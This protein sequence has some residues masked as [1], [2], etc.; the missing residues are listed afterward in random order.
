MSYVRLKGRLR[1]EG[2]ELMHHTS[3][4]KP[5]RLNIEQPDETRRIHN[6]SSRHPKLRPQTRKDEVNQV[7]WLTGHA[8][9]L[10]ALRGRRVHSLT[11]RH[12]N[13]VRQ[14]FLQKDIQRQRHGLVFLL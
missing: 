12:L 7:L 2:L 3:E 4:L 6:G 10:R 13:V 5:H 9:V 14:C 8:N 11:E 1:V